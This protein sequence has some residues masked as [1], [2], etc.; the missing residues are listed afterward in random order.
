MPLMELVIASFVLQQLVVI[1]LFNNF[2]AIHYTDTVHI[3]QAVQ[4]VS[5]HNQAL[6]LTMF[7]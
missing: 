2:T 5:D 3:F 7:T 6:M 1:T 4:A